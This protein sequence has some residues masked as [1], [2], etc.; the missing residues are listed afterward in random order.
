M[1]GLKTWG[2]FRISEEERW[3][4]RNNFTLFIYFWLCWVFMAT[5]A[6]LQLPRTGAAL[7]LPRAGFS[8]QRLPLSQSTGSRLRGLQEL[9]C[10]WALLLPGM[11][12][13]PRP[14][15]DPVSPALAGRF[16][17]TEPAGRSRKGDFELRCEWQEG[18][19]NRKSQKREAEGRI[20]AEVPYLTQIS[21]SQFPH[22]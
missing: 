4:F 3:L 9:W 17:T 12:D 8:L 22:L 13:L 1:W 14:G 16:C 2:P 6:S 11:W 21:E 15:I 20:T 18:A 19:S 10:T 7:Q 5:K